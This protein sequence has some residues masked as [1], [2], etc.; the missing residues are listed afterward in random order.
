MPLL[1]FQSQHPRVDATAWMAPNAMVIGDVVMGAGAN[2][3][4]GAVLRG[5]VNYIRI[6]A[7]T[8]VQN[9]AVIHVT[10]GG[11]TIWWSNM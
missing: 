6:G 10:T 3:W 2:L 1:A 11:C 7:G 4:F 5:G 8:H 9:N